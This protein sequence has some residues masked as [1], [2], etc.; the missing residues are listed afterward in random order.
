MAKLID[1]CFSCSTI[2]FF[3]FIYLCK[4]QELYIFPI[5]MLIEYKN[6]VSFHEDYDQKLIL[7]CFILRIY[8]QMYLM[9]I[10]TQMY[11]IGDGSY[12]IGIDSIV[13]LTC[14][15]FVQSL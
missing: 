2:V 9:I 3:P 8:C 4:V 11:I 12:N 10:L 6:Q 15:T 14:T 5:H 13:L 7:K 1:S